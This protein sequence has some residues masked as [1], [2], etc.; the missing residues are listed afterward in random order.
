MANDILGQTAPLDGPSARLYAEVTGMLARFTGVLDEDTIA[1]TP[2]LARAE[3]ETA[4]RM[5]LIAMTEAQKRIERQQYRINE[6][7]NLSITDELTSVMN[8]R[9][10]RMQLSKAMAQTARQGGSGLVLMIDLDGFKATNDSHGHAAGD[11]VLQTVAG[12][13]ANDVRASDTVGRLGGDEFAVLMPD[14]EASDGDARAQALSRR[15]NG[16]TLSWNGAM[17]TIYA[18]VGWVA[19]GVLDRPDE[20]LDRADRMMYAQKAQRRPALAMTA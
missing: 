3:T 19:F 1:K 12:V 18:S 13:L 20:I 2:E 15:L 11:A 7:E 5:A 14:L 9:G 16:Q 17:L 10:F 6:L 4:L 8:R